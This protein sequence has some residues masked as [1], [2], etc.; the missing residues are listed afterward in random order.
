[1]VRVMSIGDFNN[2]KMFY[3]FKALGKWFLKKIKPN[4]YI[5]YLQSSSEAEKAEKFKCLI[6]QPCYWL[7]FGLKNCRIR[8]VANC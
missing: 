1:M 2:V 5:E 7:K 4:L 3:S 8:L 6:Y